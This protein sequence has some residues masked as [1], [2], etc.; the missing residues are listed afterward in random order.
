M[1]F[2]RDSHPLF[3]IHGLASDISYIPNNDFVVM[4]PVIF[5]LIIIRQ[6]IQPYIRVNILVIK[7]FNNIWLFS[8]NQRK[9]IIEKIYGNNHKMID[10]L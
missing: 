2:K 5:F 6:V 3:Q 4:L 7:S 1:T 9:L 8:T 10:P